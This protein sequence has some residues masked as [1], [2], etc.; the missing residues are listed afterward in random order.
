MNKQDILNKAKE[1]ATKRVIHNQVNI[2]GSLAESYAMDAALDMASWLCK[3]F[4]KESCKWLDD[5][6][7]HCGNRQ[8]IRKDFTEDLNFKELCH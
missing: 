1:L 6:Y 2:T 7:W 3:E 8:E 5:N 4:M